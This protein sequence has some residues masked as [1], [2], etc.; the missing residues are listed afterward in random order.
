MELLLV[1]GVFLLAVLIVELVGGRAP[2]VAYSD[3]WRQAVTGLIQE[4]AAAAFA[5]SVA[6]PAARVDPRSRPS[7]TA[8]DPGTPVAVP[9]GMAVQQ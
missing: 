8:P 1:V 9:P 3:A 4:P 5:R 2:T 7:I 6:Q